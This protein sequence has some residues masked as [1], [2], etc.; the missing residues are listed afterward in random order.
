M[1]NIS[2]NN[3]SSLS[4]LNVYAPPIRSSEI[5]SFWGTSI[6][7]SLFRTQKVLLTTLGRKYL[8]GSSFLI[9]FFLM[10]LTSLLFSIA[11]LAITPFLTSPLLP[12]LSPYLASGRCFRT[13]ALIT[14][15]FHQLSFFLPSSAPM[16]VP[17]SSIFRNLVGITLP[18]TSTVTVFL[19]R[20]TRRFFFPLLLLSLLCLH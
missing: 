3:S 17:L 12:S 1:V 9:S 15:H 10:L 5:F 14:F 19:Q 8:I 18:F 6:A 11:R 13:W 16:N 20:N 4:F 2:P 7:L